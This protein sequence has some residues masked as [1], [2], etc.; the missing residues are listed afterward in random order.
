[1]CKLDYRFKKV[2]PKWKKGDDGLLVTSTTPLYVETQFY[3]QNVCDEINERFATNFKENVI[4]KISVNLYDYVH[5]YVLHRPG[6]IGVIED[7][8]HELADEY[9]RNKLC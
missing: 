3:K 9:W 2:Y 8:W 1:M 7:N 5:D 4:E 6:A